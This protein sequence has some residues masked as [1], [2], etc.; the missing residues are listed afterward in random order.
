MGL[1]SIA[2]DTIF[3]YFLYS[4]GSMLDL[5]N[6]VPAGPG[7]TSSDAPIPQGIN[8]LGQ[9]VLTEMI[10]FQ[11]LA[12]LISPKYSCQQVVNG[13]WTHP[14]LGYFGNANLDMSFTPNFNL[15]LLQAAQYCGFVNFD[16]VQQVTY[17]VDPSEFWAWNIGGAF[18]P[19]VTGTVNLTSKRTPYS[20]P[21]PGGGYAPAPG[22]DPS[23]FPPD[24]SYPFYYDIAGELVADH[25]IGGYT[26]TFHDAP[27][28]GCLPG[29]FHA[30]KVQCNYGTEPAG[31]YGGYA[32]NLAGVNSDGTATVLS[33]ALTWTS[34][35]NGTTGGIHVKKTNLPA[36]GNGTGGITITSVQENLYVAAA[37]VVNYYS[38]NDGTQFTRS[39]V[40]K[41]AITG[42]GTVSQMINA[43]NSV[44][45]TI[46]NS[47]GYA[48]CGFYFR[49]GTLG[50]FNGLQIATSAG[51]D[52]VSVNIW[53]DVD[54]NGE[55]FT[56]N[57]NVLSG[58]GNDAYILGPS[59]VQ[60]VLN[61]DANSNFNS[62]IPGGGN[63]T[64]DQLKSGAVAGITNATNIAIW[65]GIATDGGSLNATIN[66]VAGP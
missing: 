1:S 43:D 47:P 28:D 53:F 10:N 34:N 26:L 64:L 38:I 37:Q 45:L 59:S 63:Y 29:G 2:G 22:N 66:A 7:W 62:L 11:P 21:P 40:P 17:Q 3:H 46:S 18:D 19:T 33:T 51:S 42:N 48:D 55:F 6:L 15:T 23:Q 16:W 30:G 49:A 54:N 35:Y 27:A 44:T 13:G 60:N 25:E 20:D 57:G 56:W 39:L 9:M 50:D 65:V 12:F 36:D 14:P 8:D 41:S 5:N 58:L 32:T 24:Y 52:P 4:G 61:V 31:S